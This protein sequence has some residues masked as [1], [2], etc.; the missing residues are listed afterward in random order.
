[1]K[2]IN[3][4]QGSPEWMSYRAG[5]PTA[6]K[7]SEIVTT[8]GE[9]S[10]SRTKYLY[11]LAGEKITGSKEE[12]YQSAAMSRGIEME[13]EARL[14]FCMLHDAEVQEVG[15][16]I[17]D[18]GRW[19]CS[20]D[21]LI[22]DNGGIEIKCPQLATQVDYLLTGKIPSTYYQQ[23]QVSMFVTGREYWWFVS[24]YPS[25]KPLMIKAE[26]DAKFH[27]ALKAELVRFSEEL[28]T[29]VT[30]LQEVS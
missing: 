1:M 10:K 3:V 25:M 14:L 17:E 22:G 28:G 12:S 9:P 2:I 23:V 6:S 24:Y 11:Q 7:F 20:P 8:K 29:I 16:C 19:G 5:L 26:P 4:D 27:A 18:N 15:L 30:K 21:G 13:A